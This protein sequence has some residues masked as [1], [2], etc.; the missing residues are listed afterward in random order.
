MTKINWEAL[1]DKSEKELMSIIGKIEH[2]ADDL[3][4]AGEDFYKKHEAI[5]KKAICGNK[6]G[7]SGEI[8]KA[9]LE[10]LIDALSK[11][12][13]KKA[14]ASSDTHE[15]LAAIAVYALKQGLDNYCKTETA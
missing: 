3:L 1:R 10:T 7:I 5:I 9:N 8:T 12:L 4:K 13:G 2:G 15:G 14:D 6:S 11:D